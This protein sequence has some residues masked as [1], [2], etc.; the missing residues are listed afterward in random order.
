MSVAP[1]RHGWRPALAWLVAAAASMA[2]CCAPIQGARVEGPAVLVARPTDVEIDP[3]GECR[4]TLEGVGCVLSDGA[5]DIRGRVIDPL[6]SGVSG[7]VDFRLTAH[8]RPR[9]LDDPSVLWFLDRNADGRLR[10]H[11]A[12][13]VRRATDGRWAACVNEPALVEQ[14]DRAAA[15][16]AF[17]LGTTFA[18]RDRR[19]PHDF[20]GYGPPYYRVVGDTAICE[21]G[22]AIDALIPLVRAEVAPPE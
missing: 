9:Y 2:T 14:A 4:V 21:R 22:I 3:Q 18:H 1:T 17:P 19:H 13:P 7:W 20:Y 12:H 16:V 5:F 11:D 6:R 15:W 10:A 8:T